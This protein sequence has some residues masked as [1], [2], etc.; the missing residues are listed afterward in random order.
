MIMEKFHIL[1]LGAGSLGC[2]ILKNLVLSGFVNIDVI[3]YDTN[4]SV[5]D[6][7]RQLMF[8]YE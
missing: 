2:E 4:D 3:D 1:V 7:K 8:R 6:V 5:S